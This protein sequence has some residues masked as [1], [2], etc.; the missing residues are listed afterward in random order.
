[1]IKIEERKILSITHGFI[2]G[3][4][5]QNISR[6]AEIFSTIGRKHLLYLLTINVILRTRLLPAG[7]S[8]RSDGDEESIIAV[9]MG[10][11]ASR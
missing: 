2:S 1:M 5:S 4:T 10:F 8:G 11:S 9:T 3:C 7:M 6:G